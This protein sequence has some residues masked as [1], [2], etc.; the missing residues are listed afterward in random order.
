MI[1]SDFHNFIPAASLLYLNCQ[2]SLPGENYGSHKFR[3]PPLQTRQCLQPRHLVMVRYQY[4]LTISCCLPRLGTCRLMPLHFFGA[5]AFTSRFRLERFAVY[6]SSPLLPP[7][8]QDSLR[9]DAGYIFHG[10]TFTCKV[11][12][13]SCRTPNLCKIKLDSLV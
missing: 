10:R 9:G 12:A 7:E 2:Y 4:S 8:T 11:G 1:N 13:A 3:R 6:A 5:T